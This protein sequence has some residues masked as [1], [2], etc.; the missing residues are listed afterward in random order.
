MRKAII[1]RRVFIPERYIAPDKLKELRK[2]LRRMEVRHTIVGAVQGTP[3]EAVKIDEMRKVRGGWSLPRYTGMEFLGLVGDTIDCNVPYAVNV[4]QGLH[5]YRF[6]ASIAPRDDEQAVF[7]NKLVKHA[8]RSNPVDMI[9]IA[10]TGAGKTVAALQLAQ[11]LK[12]KTIIV[13]DSNKIAKGWINNIVKFWGQEFCDQ[14]VGRAQQDVCDYKDK[15]FVIALAQ[16]LA[17]RNYGQDFYRY[18]GL[19]VYDELQ[20]FGSPHYN[21]VMSQFYARVRAGFTAQERKSQF[22]QITRAHLGPPVVVSKQEVM[23]PVCYHI[24]NQLTLL[25]NTYSDGTIVNSLARDWKRNQKIAKLINERG[26]QRG[27][28]V[29]VLSDRVNHLVQLMQLCERIGIPKDAMGLH[30]GEFESDQIQQI[31]YTIRNS[32]GEHGNVQ[33]LFNVDSPEKAQSM[34]NLL[35]LG[36]YHLFDLPKALYNRLQTDPVSVAFTIRNITVKPTQKQLDIITNSCQ[37]IFATSQIFSKGV[38]VPRLDMG[39]E[40]LPL[41]NIKQPLGRILRIQEGKPAPEWYGIMDIYKADFSDGARTL[42]TAKVFNDFS[43][44]KAKLRVNAMRE[45]GAR[46]IGVRDKEATAQSDDWVPVAQ[47]RV[48]EFTID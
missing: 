48:Q 22:R 43:K 1:G 11:R 9:A 14:Y 31:C 35:A 39:I 41:G 24:R 20:V 27:R 12:T 2:Q 6:P 44:L 33:F 42:A 7:F 40:A 21:S 45:S 46:V 36:E 4:R 5:S 15:I 23:T 16:S 8:E 13:V 32:N 34:M 29:L 47:A 19:V 28:N 38:D 18:F 25:P 30:V 10:T 37:L 3:G 26:Y 17:R